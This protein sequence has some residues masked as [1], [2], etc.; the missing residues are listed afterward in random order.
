MDL[1]T[2][3]ETRKKVR[4][5]VRAKR[6][7]SDFHAGQLLD[8]LES[9]L[10]EIDELNESFD[11]RWKAD[12]RAIERWHKAH[13]GKDRVWPDHADLCVWLMDQLEKK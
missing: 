8:D 10:T 3:E 2:T 5:V 7:I 11:L 4:E 1:K 12:I 6:Y 9:A 13:P